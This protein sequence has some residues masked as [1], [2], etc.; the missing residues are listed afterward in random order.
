MTTPYTGPGTGGLI[1]QG[2][3]LGHGTSINGSVFTPGTGG[4]GNYIISNATSN[5]STGAVYIS[6]IPSPV[7]HVNAQGVL[8]DSV[9]SFT[10]KFRPQLGQPI[11][12]ELPDGSKLDIDGKGN[13][14]IDDKDTKVTY[15]GNNCRE[16]NRFINASDLIADFIEDMGKM[17]ARQ[18]QVLNV[19]IE[20]FINWLIHKAA[21]KDQEPSPQDVPRLEYQVKKLIPRCKYCG[22]FL[23]S[24][25]VN[26]GI[27]F[28][29]SSHMDK[30]LLKI[31]D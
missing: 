10:G 28:C 22:K 6:N 21:E 19:P 11:S 4:T 27:N 16:F 15:A 2:H 23:T 3:F 26:N 24:K 14:K 29:N 5:T 20:L 9:I 30:F 7:R 8:V 12:I 31:K 13:W 1:G 18:D 25:L 17:G